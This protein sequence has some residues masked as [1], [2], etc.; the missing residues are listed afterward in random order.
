[1][2]LHEYQAKELLARFGVP[3]PK[4]RVARTPE[5]AE[6]ITKELGGSAVTKAQLPVAGTSVPVLDSPDLLEDIHAPAR[7]RGHLAK[8]MC[9]QALRELA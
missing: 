9:E 4:G 2:K 7:Y 5:E 1:M 3:V 6:A 8:V